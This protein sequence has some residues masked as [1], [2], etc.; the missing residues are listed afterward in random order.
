MLSDDN[1]EL[2][3]NKVFV[4]L[5]LLNLLNYPLTVLPDVIKFVVQ[6]RVSLNRLNRFLRSEELDPDSVVKDKSLGKI[7]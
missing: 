3:A 1:H 7:Q 2:T 5:S 6:A 4:S